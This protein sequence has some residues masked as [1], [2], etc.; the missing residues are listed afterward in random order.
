MDKKETE[1]RITRIDRFRQRIAGMILNEPAAFEASFCHSKEP[2]AF[3]D[4]LSGEYKPIAEG[5]SWGRKWD[6]AWFHLKGDIPEEWAGKKV[7]AQLDFSGEGLVLD[8][9]GRMLQ[10]I[11]NGSIFDPHFA[12]DTVPLFDQCEGGEAVELWVEAAANSLF[13]VFTDPDP[14]AD[15][16]KRY[17]QFDASVVAMKLRVFNETA[18]HLSLDLRVLYGMVQRLPEK[19]VRRARIVRTINEAIDSFRGRED[20]ERCR[21]MVSREL[22]K[23][24]SASDLSV[25][26]VGHA[27]IDTVWLWPLRE[28]IRKCARTFASQLDLIDRY[29]DYVFGASQPQQYAFVKK[30]YPELY[31]RIKKA[32]ADGRWELL[33][34]MWVEADCNLISG[35]SMIR[36]ILHGK[37]YFKD[38]FGVEVT[39]LWLPDVFGYS[40]A[41]PQILSKSGIEYFLTT[42][43][44]WNQYNE[45]PHHTFLWRGIDGSEILTHFPPENT[46]N[47]QLDTEFLMPAVDSFHEKDFIDEF[48]S[49]FGVGDGGGGPKAESIECGRR[50]ANLEGAPRVK[51][52]RADAFFEG[53]DKYRGE[54]STWVGELYLELHRGT[55]TTQALVKKRS[56]QIE[57]RLRELEMLCSCLPSEDYPA[58]ELDAIWKTLL[59]HQFHDNIPGSSI[60]RVY[61]DTHKDY[62][63]LIVECDK[64]EA[65]TADKLFD[66]DYDSLVLFNSLHYPY[67]RP[68]VLPDGWGGDSAVVDETGESLPQ[69]TEDGRSVIQADV[70]PYSFVT[71]RRSSETVADSPLTEGLVLENDLVRYEFSDNGTLAYAYD[72]EFGCDI[73]ELGQAGN[74]LML[75]DDHPNNWDAWDIDKFYEDHVIEQAECK[76]VTPLTAGPVRQGLGFEFTVGDSKIKQRVFLAGNSRQLDFETTVDWREK[77]RMLRV[78]FPVNVRSEQASFDIQY[79]YVKRPTHRNTSWDAARFEVVGHRYADLSDNDYGAALL[80]DCKYG[81]KVH[82]NVLDLDLL[83]SPT[84]PDPDADM[85]EHSFTYSML[86]HTGDLV[87]S[88]VIAGAAQLNQRAL[89]IPGRRTKALC[90][91]VRLEGEGVSLEVVKMAEKDDCLILRIVERL[92]GHSGCE[93]HADNSSAKLVETDL[94]EWHD[95][96]SEI[97]C[98]KPVELRFEPFEIR[99]FKLK[100]K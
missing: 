94:M 55:Y 25:A 39:N 75:Y 2:V 89:V 88:D 9:G 24:A 40:A 98:N 33:G 37:N 54:V 97:L 84:Y 29:P 81:Y 77:H 30:H 34:G 93:L 74:V 79:G 91:P 35:E 69:Q 95:S 1:I 99:T 92:G 67:E 53:L 13:G 90:A 57:H 63:R 76:S 73:L 96:D 26:A 10:G 59:C 31:E 14:E 58:L 27:H 4:R 66:S 65:A 83:R 71:L 22:K 21:E 7:V 61:E 28:T 87:R 51:F 47:S 56:R 80:N 3:A 8:A 16:P 23:P 49:L 50:M 38:E 46:Y 6:S 20:L 41:L 100:T 85:G 32:V 60:T 78:A 42:K 48:I 72:K 15:S 70:A 5:E 82:D 12:R 43:L 45:F 11:T 36:Q 52:G 68:V 44:S 18:W 19:S 86:P 62:E 64:I 17:G